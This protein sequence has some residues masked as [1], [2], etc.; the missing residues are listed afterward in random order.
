MQGTTTQN[1]VTLI[2]LYNSEYCWYL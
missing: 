2:L 1:G